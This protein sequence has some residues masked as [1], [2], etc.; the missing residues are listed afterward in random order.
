MFLFKLFLALAISVGAVYLVFRFRRQIQAESNA[1]KA[2][3]DKKQEGAR[4]TELE[5][6]IAAYRRDKGAGQIQPN[7]SAQPAPPIGAIPLAPGG[8][9]KARAAFLS[10]PVKLAFLVLKAGLPDHHVFAH[11]R[12]ADLVDGVS[13]GALANLPIDLVVCSKE[14][15]IV[16]A[17]DLDAGMQSDAL[18]AREKEQRLRT[19]GIRYLRFAPG[20]F[21]KPAEVREVIYS[22]QGARDARPV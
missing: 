14:L 10:G 16:A 5:E 7:A 9:V 11:T 15:A 22:E 17:V 18:L 6:F 3:P 19:A 8:A 21:P 1:S 13:V 20:A 2:A 12:V 4:A